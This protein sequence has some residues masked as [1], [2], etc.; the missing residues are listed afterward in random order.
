ML[1]M[2]SRCSQGQFPNIRVLLLSATV[3]SCL[4]DYFPG[5]ELHHHVGTNG[6]HVE[7]D[8]S[9]Q[10]KACQ[11]MCR[12]CSEGGQRAVMCDTE[13]MT[14]RVIIGMISGLSKQTLMTEVLL[15]AGL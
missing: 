2:A 9:A 11:S 5:M 8:V 1:V 12:Y 3:D 7:V 6:F 4:V 14:A 10:E 13:T 15:L